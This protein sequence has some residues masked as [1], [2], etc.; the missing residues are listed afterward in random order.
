M[1]SERI[2][3][4]L[5]TRLPKSELVEFLNGV[6]SAAKRSAKLAN[7]AGLEGA[8]KARVAG[9]TRFILSENVLDNTAKSMGAEPL[10]GTIP[11]TD[12]RIYQTVHVK[13]GALLGLATIPEPGI[14]PAKNLTR[15][16]LSSIV[17]AHWQPDLFKT[18]P[19]PT[20][21]IYAVLIV[22]RDPANISDLQEVAIAVISAKYDQYLHYEKLDQFLKRYEPVSEKKSA[23][24]VKP[25][26]KTA[27]P[28]V[29]PEDEAARN[30]EQKKSV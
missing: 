25:K 21:E 29:A 15:A 6:H 20:I 22:C 30:I 26:L 8:G 3:K 23:P 18:G 19:H 4:A 9:F 17:N 5:I 1:K 7:D 13:N 2:A 16:N 12:L 24:A 27:S 11:A 28:Y 14:L 10:S